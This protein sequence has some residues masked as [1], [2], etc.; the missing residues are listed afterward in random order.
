MSNSFSEDDGN[1]ELEEF[2]EFDDDCEIPADT[3]GSSDDDESDKWYNTSGTD[4]TFEEFDPDEFKDRILNKTAQPKQRIIKLIES[5]NLMLRTETA[6]IMYV[7]AILDSN[8]F[9]SNTSTEPKKNF[10]IDSFFGASLTVTQEIE[11][12]IE[13]TELQLYGSFAGP[14]V[15][16]DDGVVQTIFTV[17]RPYLRLVLTRTKGKDRESIINRTHMK[18]EAS[19]QHTRDTSPVTKGELI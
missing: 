16:R 2:E 13:L 3:T 1:E 15:E 9:M 14:D 10:S 6:L 17:M 4:D 12:L 5:S 19:T 7:S 18:T 11:N 8:T